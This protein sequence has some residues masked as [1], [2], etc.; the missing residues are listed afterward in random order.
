MN[1]EIE[2]V[3]IIFKT[4]LDVGFTDMPHKV[5]ERYFN[6]YIPQSIETARELRAAGGEEQFIWTIGSWLIV[7]YL[8][9]APAEKVKLLEEAIRAGDITWHAY[10]FTPHHELM[11]GGMFEYE[12]SLA[13]KL[14]ERFNKHTCAAKLS[15]IPGDTRAT[16][17]HLAIAGVKFLHIGVN[18][19]S[20][21]PEVPRVCLWKDPSGSEVVLMY[22]SGYGNVMDRPNGA[23]YYNSNPTHAPGMRDAIYFAFTLDNCGPHT[24]ESVRAVFADVRKIFPNAKIIASTMDAFADKI[25]EVRE[26]LPVVTDEIGNTWI[27]GG[28][29]DPKKL[30]Q[31]RALSRLRARWLAEGKANPADPAFDQ[32]SRWLLLIP[33]HTWGI[34]ESRV[35]DEVNWNPGQIK[36]RRKTLLYRIME[37][38][39]AEARDYIHKAVE[40]LDSSPLAAEAQAVLEEMEPRVPSTTGFQR[41]ADPTVVFDTEHFKVR[42]DAQ[43]GAVIGLLAK[44]SGRQ[45]AAP[46]HPLGVFRH[47]SFNEADWSRFFE[48]YIICNEPWVRRD[49]GKPNIDR[50]GAV[51]AFRPTRLEKM[52]FKEDGLATTFLLEMSMPEVPPTYYGCPKLVSVVLRFPKSGPGIEW[53]LQWFEKEANRLPEACWFSFSPVGTRPEG[54]KMEKMDQMISPL[55]VISKGGRNLHGVNRGVFYQANGEQ[56]VIETLDAGIVA[57]G[58]PKLLDLDNRL[59]ELDQGWH[60][61]LWN[62]KWG[63]NFPTW[64]DDDARFRFLL[65][66][67]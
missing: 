8:E 21:L 19:A 62:N 64:Y 34:N 26:T 45:W 52:W 6:V 11:D 20:T 29:T 47:Q 23:D 33:E 42:F 14:D 17:R 38:S 32:F 37:E 41:T 44:S 18:K 10:P 51:S 56:L 12:L 66:F 7:E 16:V 58:E 22:H 3:H 54:W 39:W 50:A 9:K 35:L 60:F 49:F 2:T 40:A 57:P 28:G 25:W 27:H 36:A 24:P 61:N 13:R 55:E 53:D 46:D 15:D 48:Q 30:S 1:S 67:E 59:P 5:V 4:H 65:K 43:T 31:F 63:C